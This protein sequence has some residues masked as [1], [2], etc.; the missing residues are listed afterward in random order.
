MYFNFCWSRMRSSSAP[1]TWLH[2]PRVTSRDV[3]YSSVW[4]ASKCLWQTFKDNKS[5]ETCLL[6]GR[7]KRTCLWEGGMMIDGIVDICYLY[8]YLVLVN[9]SSPWH[10]LISYNSPLYNIQ[11][12][13]RRWLNPSQKLHL[14]TCDLL[15]TNNAA[16]F[17]S[18]R[19]WLFFFKNRLT[20]WRKDQFDIKSKDTSPL[21]ITLTS[22]LMRMFQAWGNFQT[23]LGA[24]WAA[25]RL[26]TR[27]R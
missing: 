14:E 20:S 7:D 11:K 19:Q 3:T 1:V 22:K 15:V 12:E 27:G 8:K 21:I 4:Q 5:F 17:Y 26:W 13:R 16:I 10:V 2:I 24:N 23:V 9:F 25:S 6:G 18:N